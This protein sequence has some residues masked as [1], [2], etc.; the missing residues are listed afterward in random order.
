MSGWIKLHRSIISNEL[1]E[2][3]PFTYAQAW[4]DILL[5]A[6][7]QP[8][9]III[10]GI[11]LTID[12]GQLGWSEVTMGERW[13]WSRDKVRR[14]L[15]RLESASMIIQQKTQVTTILTVCN[16]SSFQDLNTPDDTADNTSDDTPDDTQHK[17]LRSKE[18]KN[19]PTGKPLVTFSTWLNSLKE[20][21]ELP[22]PEDDSIFEYATEAGIPSDYLRITWVEFKAEFSEKDKKQRDWRAHFR[23][24]IRKNYYALWWID[25]GE[26]K[27]T[28]RGQQAMTAM[29]NKRV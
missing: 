16:Y 25:S 22:I 23:N 5:N 26:Y 2:A 4:I 13:K 6:N 29:N 1:W 8:K 9:N 21:G 19:K 17:K 20:S 7:Y 11:S 15:K 3:E 18:V 12:R 27:L 24:F 10:R 28:T 14:F